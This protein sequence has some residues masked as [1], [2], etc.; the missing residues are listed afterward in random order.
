M[1]GE[2][3]MY[4]NELKEKSDIELLLFK[5]RVEEEMTMA[6]PYQETSFRYLLDFIYS[7]MEDRSL[8]Q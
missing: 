2:N 5:I 1:R 6:L 3:I 8:L 7:E 4:N